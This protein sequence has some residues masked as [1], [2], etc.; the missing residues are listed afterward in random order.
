MAET[1][2]STSGPIKE[3]RGNPVLKAYRINRFLAMPLVVAPSDRSWMNA[4]DRRFANR[5]LPLLIAN[6]SG[7][8]IVSNHKVRVTWTGG[9]RIE[10][11]QVELLSGE[12]PCP[13]V[14]HFGHGILTWTVPYL[15][16]T[17]P[18]YNLLVRG[19]ANWPK[20]GIYPLEG[21][22][23]ADW[24]EAT[25]TMNWKITRPVHRV[26]FE[27]GEPIGMIVPQRRGELEEFHAEISDIEIAPRLQR[28][29]QSW[30][31]ERATFN[32]ELRQ[33]GSKAEKRGWQKHYF[34]GV[35]P[36]G[37]TGPQ[38]QTKLN[39]MGFVETHE[40]HNSESIDELESHLEGAGD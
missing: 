14:S 30:A 35:S 10:D 27:V 19:P 12:S 26:T 39:L 32:S 3:W 18:G 17:P 6:Q 13:A 15:F 34:Q 21:V 25:F 4:T 16:R 1:E 37:E 40:M 2:G 8:F 23:E 36:R 22:V 33:P 28:E 9:N 38:H 29:H 20:D 5:C 31:N 24:T 7:W 11:L